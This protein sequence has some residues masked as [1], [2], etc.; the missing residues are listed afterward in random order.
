MVYY[1]RFPVEDPETKWLRNPNGPDREMKMEEDFTFV[2]KKGNYHTAFKGEVVD[3]SSIPP[4]LWSIFQLS[5]FVGDH[6]N[7]SIIHDVLCQRKELPSKKVHQV[8]ADMLHVLMPDTKFLLM[9]KATVMGNLVKWF[10]PKW[11]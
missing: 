1:G 4:L 8:W 3:G 5:P 6:R 9:N 10:G 2:D 7:A 11:K